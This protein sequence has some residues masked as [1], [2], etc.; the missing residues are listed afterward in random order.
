[1]NTCPPSRP[2]AALPGLPPAVLGD[3]PRATAPEPATET[4]FL[5]EIQPRTRPSSPPEQPPRV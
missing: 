1:M 4:A 3:E 2:E 5:T